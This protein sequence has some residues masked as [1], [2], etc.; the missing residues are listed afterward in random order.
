[1]HKPKASQFSLTRRQFFRD[2][3]AGAALFY[4][5][6][7]T[8]LK[9]AQRLSTNEKVNV[10]GIGVGSRGGADIDEVAT[11]G[12][13]IVALCD[14]DTKY[15]GKLFAKYPNARQFKDYRVMLDK[16]GKEIDAVVIGTPDHT[17]A[18][19]AMEAMRRGKHVYCEKPLA[20][21]V[22]EIRKLMAAAHKYKVV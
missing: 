14:V 11:E 10:A 13:N 1:M 2:A 16:I 6:P 5:A 4:I 3:S 20:H 17:H 15:A 8:V 22:L 12:Q 9:A 21:N 7:G 18:V 19:I